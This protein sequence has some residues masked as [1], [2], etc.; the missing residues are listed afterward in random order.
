MRFITFVVA[1]LA[2]A[3]V[4][5]AQNGPAPT[6]SGMPAAG[7]L[8]IW[9]PDPA[10]NTLADGGP[11]TVTASAGTNFVEVVATAVSANGAFSPALPA[12][13]TLMLI[14][15]QETSG[16][17]VT[18]GLTLGTSLGGADVVS[19]PV[20]LGASGLATINVG[21]L[22]EQQLGGST[23]YLGSSSWGSAVVNAQA[24]CL[25]Q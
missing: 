18:G 7:D 24:Y 12:T 6:T 11:P 20:T 17:A 22:L 14:T 2:F 15:A 23:L 13:C 10:K 1:A 8:A 5:H 16:H 3:S 9:G 25:E 21:G 4:A 19:S